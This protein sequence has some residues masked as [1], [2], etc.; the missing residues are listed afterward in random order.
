M[1]AGP[2][3]GSEQIWS[4]VCQ[5]HES[6]NP[7][8]GDQL[9]VKR[10]NHKTLEPCWKDLHMV[11]LITPIAVKVDWIRAWTLHSGQTCRMRDNPTAV[12][13]TRQPA[14]WTFILF[15]LMYY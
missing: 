3:P 15:L 8:L 2:S 4:D 11:I 14:G 1:F 5:V 10:H 6:A 13:A 9:W 7:H 12:P